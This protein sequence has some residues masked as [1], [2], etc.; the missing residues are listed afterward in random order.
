MPDGV[1]LLTAGIDTQDDRFEI[2]VVGWGRSEESWS[3]AHDV[4]E[5]DLETP[6]PWE[7]LDAYL[8]QIWRRADGRGFAIMA[9]CMD[10]GGHHTRLFMISVKRVSVAGFGLS[11][12]N[13]PVVAN[14]HRSGR[15]NA[16]HPVR[17]PDLNR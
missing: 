3:V 11:K 2:E 15:Q 1:T 8:K 16:L 4:I 9:A 17:K 13:P 5:G 14:A 6:E 7:R 10:S 12:A